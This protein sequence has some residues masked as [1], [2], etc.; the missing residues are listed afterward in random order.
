MKALHM[1]HSWI[2]CSFADFN[3]YSFAVINHNHG[4]NAI[5]EFCDG[6]QQIIEPGDG[7]DNFWT[8]ILCQKLW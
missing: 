7:L 3:L 2:L 6:F 8:W 5:S 4:Y 1:E